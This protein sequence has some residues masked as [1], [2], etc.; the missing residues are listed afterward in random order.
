MKQKKRKK[1]LIRKEVLWSGFIVILMVG[2]VFGIIFG[3]FNDSSESIEYKDYKLTASQKGWILK[4]EGKNYLFSFDPKSL[5]NLKVSDDAINMLKT[6]P[7]IDFTSDPDSAYKQVIAQA[8]YDIL[9][10]LSSKNK[11]SE[12]GF[13]SESEY[14]VPIFVCSRESEI[15]LVYLKDGNE[16]KIYTN[17]SCIIAQSSNSDNFFALR[18]RIIYSI[19]GVMD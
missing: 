6:S 16:T 17:G 3:G 13:V 10:V 12:I 9:S 1:S 14:D 5:E 11:Y 8:E 18:D 2:S 4:D 19:L 15:P 7:Q